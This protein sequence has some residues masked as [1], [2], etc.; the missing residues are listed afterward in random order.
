MN[1]YR[2]VWEIDIDAKSPK[3]AVKQAL[4]IQRDSGSE[5]TYFEVTNI[6]T[7]KTMVFDLY[8]EI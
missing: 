6:K 1:T 3:E 2:V 4:Q 7:K 5:A 8:Y